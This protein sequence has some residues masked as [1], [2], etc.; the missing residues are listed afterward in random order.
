MENA[1][2]YFYRAIG[3][4]LSGVVFIPQVLDYIGIG[5]PRDFGAK[6]MIILTIGFFFAV[7]SNNFK[8]VARF[9]ANAFKKRVS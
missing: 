5:E 1:N 9:I 2:K 8:A 3:W 4:I 7:G 6:E